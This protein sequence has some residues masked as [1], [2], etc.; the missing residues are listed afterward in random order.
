[1]AEM[2]RRD[3]NLNLLVHHGKHG[4]TYWLVDTPERRNAAFREL[5]TLLDEC[6][7]YD[8]NDDKAFLK[9]ARAGDPEAIRD[10]LEIHRPYEYEQWDLEWAA[11]ATAQST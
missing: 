6:G 8:E 3:E 10:L 4:R 9:A 11:D 7:C 5:F 1:M 2:R